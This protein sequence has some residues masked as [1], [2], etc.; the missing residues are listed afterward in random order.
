MH[1]SQ[2]FYTP[3]NYFG[4]AQM[5]KS[6]KTLEEAL[7]LIKEA[8]QAEREDELF[9]DYLLSLAPS[10]EEKDIIASI[11]DEERK[12]YKYFKEIYSFYTRKSAPSPNNITFEKPQSYIAGVRKAKFGELGAVERYRDIRAGIP[13]R[14]YRDMVFE[15]ITDELKHAHKYDYILYLSLENKYAT[16]KT[17]LGTT[18]SSQGNF[19]RQPREFTLAELAQYDGAMGRPAYVAV[20]GIVYDV[21]NEATWGGASH[22]GLMA[23]RDL[24]AQFQGCHGRESILAKLPRVGILKA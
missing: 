22:F 7:F 6:Y 16:D 9:Y 17:N 8:I 19:Y 2:P 20:N 1:Y 12:H 14:Y 11:R 23:G 13:D 15:I 4:A 10:K 3:N 24:S 18:W 5:E 21:S